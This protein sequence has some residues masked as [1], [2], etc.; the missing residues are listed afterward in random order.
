LA[1]KDSFVSSG[2][3]AVIRQ[4]E[5]RVESM[6]LLDNTCMSTL[7]GYVR[8]GTAVRRGIAQSCV[9]NLES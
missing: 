2:K 8:R 4:H 7:C 9:S 5:I 6:K 1:L 3:T